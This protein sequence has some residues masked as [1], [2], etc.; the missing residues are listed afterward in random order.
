MKKTTIAA[1]AACVLGPVSA[2]AQSSVTVYGRVDTSV[3]STGLF[4]AAVA[5][6]SCDMPENEPAP[7]AGTAEQAGPDGSS[8]VPDVIASVVVVARIGSVVVESDDED[9]VSWSSEQ[10]AAPT[11]SEPSP[12]WSA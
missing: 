9:E 8:I 10:A 1:I 6:G 3:E 5:A 12:I 2:F 4:D 11:A 7:S